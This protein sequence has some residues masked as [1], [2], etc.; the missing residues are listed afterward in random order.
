MSLW[1]RL[2]RHARVLLPLALVHFL[3]LFVLRGVFWAVF[4]KSS[5]SLAPQVLAKALFIGAKFDLRLALL[6]LLPPALLG[7]PRV[8]SLVT[9][10]LGRALWTIYLAVAAAVTSL[11]YFVDFGYFAYL[12]S[13]L[14]AQVLD[15]LDEA[16]IALRMVWESYPVVW[17]VLGIA[18][19][20]TAYVVLVRR[21]IRA[22]LA[23]DVAPFRRRRQVALVAMV[24]FL[25]GFGIYGKLQWYPLRWSDAF[26]ATDEWSAALGLNPVLHLSDTMKNKARGFDAVALA[27]HYAE[28]AAYLG[29]DRPDPATLTFRRE[30]PARPTA[31]RAPNIIVILL[32][33][34]S[35]YETGIFGNP[36]KPTPHF[37]ELAREGILFRRFYTPAFGTARSVFALVTGIPDVETHETAT[38]NPLIVRQHTIVNAFAGYEK[39]YFLGGSMNWGNVRGLLAH[40]I[41]G[42][43]LFEEGSYDAARVDVWGISDL[44]MFEKANAVLREIK[45]RPFFAVIQTSGH[46]RPYTIPKDNRGFVRLP[47]TPEQLAGAGFQELDEYNSY[48]FMDHALG[49]FFADA[50]REAYFD[51][52]IFILFGDHGR[53]AASESLARAEDAVG[54]TRVHVP[55][56]IYGRP[57][58][59]APR[60]IEA[61]ASEVDV[62]PTLAALAGLPYVNTTLGRDL[63]DPRF[64][65]TRFAFTIADHYTEPKIGLLT[66]GGYLKMSAKGG[67]A[68]FF[69]LR[70][71]VPS[72]IAGQNPEKT[73]ALA[74]Q[75]RG[76]YE[77][78]RWLMYHNA[79]PPAGQ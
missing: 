47:A 5:P 20:V 59:G 4:H 41:P 21:L 34:A 36:L 60:E 27:E 44:A 43:G 63:L 67:P 33:S 16:A 76:L 18:A 37:D 25:W 66:A 73:R 8:L 32:E 40:N 15:L 45:E 10:R 2:P 52:T 31:G 38:R 3:A 68:S 77:A 24:V 71:D 29:V 7:W 30:A 17:G 39:L 35:H 46:H 75:C 19:L 58:P 14:N 9:S 50:R 61:P 53:F 51:D 11:A 78:S 55:A 57:V 42:L 64:D 6:T 56:V 48:R 12:H 79:P 23:R 69:D 1:R 22:E 72:D 13:R 62:L 26:F 54:L 49:A 74:R 70:G 65:A 28:V